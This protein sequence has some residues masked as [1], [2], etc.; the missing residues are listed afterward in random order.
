MPLYTSS[1]DMKIDY[2]DKC[3]CE[4]RSGTFMANHSLMWH[5]G[6]IMCNDCGKFVRFF[7]AG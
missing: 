3:K 7:G 2:T 5:D 6:D 4:N 1:V